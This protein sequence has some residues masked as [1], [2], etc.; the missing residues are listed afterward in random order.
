MTSSS[1]KYREDIDGLRAL[2]VAI[3]ILFHFEFSWVPG[4]FVGVDVFFVIS[5]FLITSLI[6]RQIAEGC[7]SLIDF[8]ERRF[9][10]IYPNLL[11]VLATTTALGIITMVPLTYGPFGRSLV[12]A[13]L[14][15]SNF[16][17]IGGNGYFDPDN[18]TKPLLHTWSLGVEEQ[19]YLV[20]PWLLIFA[21]KRDYSAKWLIGGFVALSLALSIGAAMLNWAPSYF[22]LPTRFWELG[23]GALIAILQSGDRLPSTQRSVLGIA[24]LLAIAWAALRLSEFDPFPGYVALAPTLGAAAIIWAN[25]GIVGKLLSLRPF[26]WIGRLSFAL[27]LWHWPL[28]SIAA[29]IGLP[30]TDTATRVVITA[31]MSVLSVVGYFLWEQPI[32]QKRLLGQRKP[33]FAALA[34][35]TLALVGAGILIFETRGLPQR[36][37]ADLIAM[38][39][40]VK[41]DSYLISQR[42][43]EMGMESSCPLGDETSD[44][45]SFVIIGDSHSHAIAAEIGD[46]AKAYHLRGLYLGRGGCPPL[47]NITRDPDSPCPLRYESALRKIQ[48][49]N[50]KL[51]ISILQWASLVGGPDG[52]YKTLLFDHNKEVSDAE[53]I[54]VIKSALEKT[55]EDIGDRQIVTSITIPEYSGKAPV[56]WKAWSE[57]F[58]LPSSL[59]ELTYDQF[60]SQQRYVLEILNEASAKHKNFKSVNPGRILCPEGAC[61]RIKGSTLLY[62]NNTHLSHSGAL[63][64]APL[65]EPYLA[66]LTLIDKNP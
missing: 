66:A 13:A 56:I 10:R 24:G 32:R 31:V 9:R 3:V 33:F 36:L 39:E 47:A 14:S 7:F 48:E 12:W 63:L 53:R 19:F 28:I 25:G 29:G 52:E 11:I 16:A 51:V 17:F 5:G 21:T 26:V 4:G 45:I 37:P 59:V 60:I 42:C 20:F 55:I 23:T 27:Y 40:A 38:D 15:G 18:L 35:F 22:L 61:I 44:K 43:P 62:Q 65:F 58:G 57:R 49:N 30:P 34:L 50:P 64:V 8:Y 46:I 2:A 54:P 6:A 41:R 1:W